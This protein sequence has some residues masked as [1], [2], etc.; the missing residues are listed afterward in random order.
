MLLLRQLS[1]MFLPM[2]SQKSLQPLPSNIAVT[3]NQLFIR[4]VIRL[5]NERFKHV[6]LAFPMSYCHSISVAR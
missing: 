6:P 1:L 3:S 2:L 5:K 4:S